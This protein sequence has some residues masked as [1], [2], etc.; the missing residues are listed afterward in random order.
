MGD[1]PDTKFFRLMGEGG[2]RSVPLWLVLIGGFGTLGGGGWMGSALNGNTSKQLERIAE[3]QEE[4]RDEVRTLQQQ[5]GE[6]LV[7]IEQSAQN[8]D[9]IH[10]DLAKRLDD[11]EQR[12]RLLE[13]Q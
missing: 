7:L 11:H 5:L 8:R 2:G 3:R 12:I 4:A 9:M 1:G 13:R 6:L 10:A